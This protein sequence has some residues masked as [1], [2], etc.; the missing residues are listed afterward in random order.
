MP[1]YVILFFPDLDYL[2]HKSNFCKFGQFSL[3]TTFMFSLSIE[4]FP[5]LNQI[6]LD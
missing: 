1:S 4:Q 6:N 2:V 3:A 5:A